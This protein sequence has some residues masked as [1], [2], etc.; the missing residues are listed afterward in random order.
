MNLSRIVLVQKVS[1]FEVKANNRPA[2]ICLADGCFHRDTRCISR[3]EEADIFRKGRKKWDKNSP[4]F[5]FVRGRNFFF[6]NNRET[7]KRNNYYLCFSWIN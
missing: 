6:E 5:V 1:D 3:L 4:S 7:L 2:A